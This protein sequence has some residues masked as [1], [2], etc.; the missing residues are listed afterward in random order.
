[1]M[2]NNEDENAILIA[3]RSV[4]EK[5]KDDTEIQSIMAVCQ[6]LEDGVCFVAPEKAW[7]E[8]LEKA[9]VWKMEEGEKDE[10]HKN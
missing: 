7:D 10:G 5:F 8:M 6:W 4:A 1:M 3:S 9:E 2:P